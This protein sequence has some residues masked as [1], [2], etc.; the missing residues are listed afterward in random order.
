MSLSKE[1]LLRPIKLEK[2]AFL[3]GSGISISSGLP[4]G[5]AFSRRIAELLGSDSREVA[6]ISKLLVVSDADKSTA[7]IR[8]EQ[9]VATF[10]ATVDPSLT[11]LDV[12]DSSLPPNSTHTF[13]AS[14]L[15]HGVPVFTTN[16][17]H[18]IEAAY[19]CLTAC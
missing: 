8:F 1:H 5:M 10:R 9:L 6:E 14:A 16:F 2:V 13:L 17:D 15:S 18:L 4:S 12:F 11:L 19:E 3:V 7:H